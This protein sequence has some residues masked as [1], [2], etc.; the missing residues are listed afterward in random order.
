MLAASVATRVIGYASTIAIARMLGGEQFGRLALASVLVGYFGIIVEFGTGTW[1]VRAVARDKEHSDSLARSTARVRLGLFAI[2]LPLIIVLASLLNKTND[3]KIAMVLV[4]ATLLPKAVTGVYVAVMQGH[5]RM[6]LVA[7]LSVVEVTASLTL[8][9][10]ALVV[11]PS[12]VTLTAATLITALVE[13]F[14]AGIFCRRA[15]CSFSFAGKADNMR[16]ITAGG[17]PFLITAMLGAAYFR[18]DI[19]L[20]SFLLGDAQVGFYSAAT[21]LIESARFIPWAITFPL[22]P[23]LSKGFAEG[24]DEA[25]DLQARA[26]GILLAVGI[27]IAAL[28]SAFSREIISLMYGSQYAA[29]AAPL[30]WLAWAMPLMYVNILFCFSAYAQDRQRQVIGLMSVMFVFNMG[31]NLWAVPTYGVTGA[32]MS[33]VFT[34]IIAI[35]Y[36]GA[37]LLRKP[38][39]LSRFSG[40]AVK[41]AF[42]CAAIVCLKP[43]SDIVGPVFAALVVLAIY[44]ALLIRLNAVSLSEVRALSSAAGAMGRRGV[45]NAE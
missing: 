31:F 26:A 14:A 2:S 19:L 20:L 36:Y 34:E 4:A 32:A 29:A 1:L 45:E 38:V 43:A 24:R 21:K 12:I 39:A 25:H 28:T 18:A 15:R 41:I 33:T 10:T 37:I 27:P 30:K 44:C 9:V 8:C 23:V 11:M 17:A 5:E 3:V 16:M 40:T 35:V 42:A 13:L 22:Y 6:D 7:A